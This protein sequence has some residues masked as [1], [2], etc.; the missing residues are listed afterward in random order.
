MNGR[1]SA[2]SVV[3]DEGVNPDEWAELADYVFD[4]APTA[5]RAVK[6]VKAA[7]DAAEDGAGAA[8][9]RELERSV[10]HATLSLAVAGLMTLAH[11]EF[12]ERVDWVD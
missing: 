11:L 7:R 6:A 3:C 2:L 5:A 1:L 10:F 4:A 9:V 12:L 8:E